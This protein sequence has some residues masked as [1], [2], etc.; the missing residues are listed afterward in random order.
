M[1]LPVSQLRSIVNP[2]YVSKNSV[3]EGYIVS[4]END[5]I[6]RQSIV[7]ARESVIRMSRKNSKSQVME[8]VYYSLEDI[9]N[10]SMKDKTTAVKNE[11]SPY[12]EASD[13]Y[14]VLRQ[15]RNKKVDHNE[16]RMYSEGFILEEGE[17]MYDHTN[18]SSR[19]LND[20]SVNVED[21]RIDDKTDKESDDTSVIQQS[22]VTNAPKRTS[23]IKSDEAPVYA[24]VRKSRSSSL[25]D[26]K[27]KL[28]EPID[29]ANIILSTDEK[30][31]SE[32]MD[33]AW[34]KLQDSSDPISGT[35]DQEEPFYEESDVAYDQ[36]RRQ[37]TRRNK[38]LGVSVSIYSEI[39]PDTPNYEEIYNTT[40]SAGRIQEEEPTTPTRSSQSERN[41]KDDD[42]INDLDDDK[43]NVTK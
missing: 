16:Y 39:I 19:V 24:T 35:A 32:A 25:K 20:E 33:E 9:N 29:M 8:S 38:N 5:A 3:A 2:N 40:E 12:V 28:P 7:A 34:K 26:R 13:S 6:S 14:D 10:T 4:Y 31:L 1:S 30:N 22:N 23:S 43:K 17:E 36:L 18:T 41:S 42:E 15:K 11:E 37:R 21:Q 27:S